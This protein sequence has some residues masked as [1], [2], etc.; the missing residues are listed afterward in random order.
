MDQNNRNTEINIEHENSEHIADCGIIQDLLPLYQDGICSSS[1]KKMIE[2]HLPA[3]PDCSLFLQK[4]QNNNVEGKLVQEKTGI[5]TAYLKKEKKRT[6][7]IGICTAAILMVPVIVCLICNLAIGHG[8]DWFFIVLTSLLLTASL[9]VVP[10]ITEEHTG[11]W[12]LGSFTT[13]LLLLLL[14]ICLYTQ[15]S[16]FFL[17]AVPSLF[18]LSVL[19]MPYVIRHVPLPEALANH[20]G[21]L[22]MLWD[23]LWLYA[24]IAV[25]GVH[26]SHP[27][28]WRIALEI[29]T[30]CILLPWTLFLIIRYRKSNAFIKAGICTLFAGIFCSAINSIVALILGDPYRHPG[31]FCSAVNSIA[32]LILRDAYRYQLIQNADFTHWNDAASEVVTA[33]S[34]LIITIPIGIALLIKGYRKQ[35]EEDNGE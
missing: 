17:A 19:F 14:T 29:T 18:G 5:L 4:L 26:A 20:K 1:S 10:L 21:L 23:T 24:V 32:A 25:C 31:I 30:F 22:V 12:T 13:S 6:F 2:K 3:C 33:V 27:N 7:T 15:G 34:I 28:Y 9:T 35:R 16:W 8:L 11:L